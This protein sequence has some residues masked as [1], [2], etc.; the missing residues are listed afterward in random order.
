MRKISAVLLSLT[1]ATAAVAKTPLRDVPAI[2][3]RMLSVALAIEISD[4]CNEIKPRTFKGLAY[5]N[6]L[7]GKAQK[8]GYTYDE[9]RTYVKSDTEKARMRKRGEIYVKSKGFDP[10]R[11]EDLCKLGHAEI[12]QGSL[13]GSLLKAK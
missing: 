7:K 10:T 13:I 12:A 5:L 9:I 8:M 11:A 2:D 1:I 6:S 4:K 3:D